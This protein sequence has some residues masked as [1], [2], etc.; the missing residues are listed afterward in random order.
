M[1]IIGFS[2]NKIQ[3]EKKAPAQGEI[4]ISNNIKLTDIKEEKINVGGD[5]MALST[6]FEYKVNYNPDIGNLVLT[7]Y[8]VYLGDKATQEQVLKAWQEKKNLDNKFS[9]Q[10]TNSVLAKCNIKAIELCSQVGLPS[11]IRM[12]VAKTANPAPAE[13]DSG[14]NNYIG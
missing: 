3:V 7:G 12:P 14:A 13:G 8:V 5:H 9:L 2:F 1:S 6:S 11:H 4:N 10:V